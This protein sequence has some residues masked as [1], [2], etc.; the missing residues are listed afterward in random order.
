ML[1]NMHGL[2]R[3]QFEAL[4]I[5]QYEGLKAATTSMHES[6]LN[7]QLGV[8]NIGVKEGLQAAQTSMDATYLH[9]GEQYYQIPSG[10]IVQYN[11]SNQLTG[12][13]TSTGE[14]V[15]FGDM[16]ALTHS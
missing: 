14:F 6:V 4:H 1:A 2:N 12:Y 7:N 5:G 15:A 16:T 13:Q 11:N 8:N 3:D 10:A 9:Y